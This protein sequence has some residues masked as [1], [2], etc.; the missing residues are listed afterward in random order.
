MRSLKSIIFASGLSLLAALAFST[1]LRPSYAAPAA[2]D[3]DR[4]TNLSTKLESFL[5]SR[6][7]RIVRA[8][9]V[10]GDDFSASAIVHLIKQTPPPPPEAQD[11]NV[12]RAPAAVAKKKKSESPD[13]MTFADGGSFMDADQLVKQYEQEES[14]DRP[15]VDNKPYS[16]AYLHSSGAQ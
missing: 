9:G 7:E 6:V 12:D 10:R 14:A 5:V 4:E 2:D 13:F 3:L 8:S 16:D 15:P 11:D 1:S